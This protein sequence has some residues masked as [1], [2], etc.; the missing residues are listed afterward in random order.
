MFRVPQNS[1]WASKIAKLVFN[2]MKSGV[3]PTSQGKTIE[4]FDT[5]QN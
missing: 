2:L 5:E 1:F 4:Q 3:N